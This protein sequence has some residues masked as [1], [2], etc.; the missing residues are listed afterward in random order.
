[1]G[2]ASVHFPLLAGKD[3]IVAEV[4]ELTALCDRLEARL[5]AGRTE[6]RR[7]LEAALY[8]TLTPSLEDGDSTPIRYRG[9]RP[10]G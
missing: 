8:Q 2:P 4:D 3:R 5:A 1:M 9:C 10:G 6:S 7:V